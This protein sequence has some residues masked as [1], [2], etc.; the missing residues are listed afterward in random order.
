MDKTKHKK[1][2]CSQSHMTILLLFLRTK[3]G[4]SRSLSQPRHLEPTIEKKRQK[5]EGGSDSAF[6]D[7]H[8]MHLMETG[9]GLVT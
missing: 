9:A 2:E 1:M 8:T 7:K 5:R 6:K 3:E 4:K